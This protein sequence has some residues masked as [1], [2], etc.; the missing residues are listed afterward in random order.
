MENLLKNACKELDIE[1]N[2]KQISQFLKYKE[3]LLD[4][5]E[6]INLTAITEDREII[7]KHFVDCVSI[8]KFA[9]FENKS[10]IDVGTGA[11]FPGVPIKIMQDSCN[12]TLLDSLNKRINFLQVLAQEINLENINFVH[13]RAEQGGKNPNF[14][15]KFDFCVARAVAN[16]AVLAEY[17]LPF[18][19]VGGQLI[20]LKGPNLEEELKASKKAIDVLGGEIFEIKK[21]DIPFTDISHSLVII[22]KIRQTPRQYPRKE[23]KVSKDPIN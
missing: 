9:S 23:G 13:S 20:A 17:T 3:I 7:L 14:R 8:L 15:E 19:K 1:I 6:K 4:W 21:V 2:D 12:L 18:V 11:G 16:L 22:K 5:N 10:V